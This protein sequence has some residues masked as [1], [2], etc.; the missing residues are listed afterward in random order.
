MLSCEFRKFLKAPFLQNTSGP[1]MNITVIKLQI[2]FHHELIWFH[3]KYKS[4]TNF[5][6]QQTMQQKRNRNLSPIR[7]IC[8]K[9][10]KKSNWYIRN[11][12]STVFWASSKTYQDIFHQIK[13][14]K[15]Q[16]IAAPVME[17]YNT[18]FCI[19]WFCSVLL[20][21]IIWRYSHADWKSTDK[22]SLKYFKSILKV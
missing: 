10:F 7:Q 20:A 17:N 19:I 15:L 5:V 2:G 16:D 18:N 4:V 8:V 3:M 9:A 13:L 12:P 6:S 1:L 21:T 11:P 22:W 14:N